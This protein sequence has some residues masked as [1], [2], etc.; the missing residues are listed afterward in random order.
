MM[1]TIAGS[2]RSVESHLQGPVGASGSF[3]PESQPGSRGPRD[4]D[5]RGAQ[6]PDRAHKA[7]ITL[8][9]GLALAG[10][11]TAVAVAATPP[12]GIQDQAD[13]QKAP[14]QSQLDTTLARHR[15]LGAIATPPAIAAQPVA[16]TTPAAPDPGVDVP[17]TLLV[18]LVGGLLGGAA[19]MVGW[20][21]TTRRRRPR[22]AT[23]LRLGP[24]A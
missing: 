18:G 3:A 12:T 2:H 14:Y 4:R 9:L 17:A 15:A 5:N 22:A 16:K 20:T 24:P 7:L 13:Q 8:A 19:V 21:A 10:A 23:G 1:T 6:P 11:T